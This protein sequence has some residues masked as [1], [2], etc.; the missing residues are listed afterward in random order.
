MRNFNVKLWSN[1]TNGTESWMNEHTNGRT[2]RRKLYTYQH[3]YR[4]YN[5]YQ[6]KAY[7][8]DKKTVY[9]IFEQQRYRSAYA[10]MQSE[11]AMIPLYL[12]F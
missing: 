4:G 12:P 9:A 1:S 5:N 2:E 7:H 3:K 10:S 11:I 8:Y 6:A